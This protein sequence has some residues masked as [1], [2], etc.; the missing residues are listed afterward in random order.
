MT[1]HINLESDSLAR[2]L[3]IIGLLVGASGWFGFIGLS[4]TIPYRVDAVEAKV[5]QIEIETRESRERLIRIEERLI[6][7]Q[8]TLRLQQ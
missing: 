7:I 2:K 1:K 4:L 3:K 5:K 6:H 8:T